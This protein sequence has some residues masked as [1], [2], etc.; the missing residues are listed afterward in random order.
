[1]SN[2]PLSDGGF[3]VYGV[4]IKRLR[5][6]EVEVKAVLKSYS[7]DYF[8]AAL[9][10]ELTG[11]FPN[12]FVTKLPMI[13]SKM[14]SRLFYLSEFE[15]ECNNYPEFKEISKQDVLECLFAAGYIGQHRPRTNRDFT[16]FSYRNHNESFVAEH[17]C[18]LHRGLLKALSL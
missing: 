18:I 5:L 2:P 12:D 14:G 10:D 15:D 6:N 16:V 9:K 4:V 11:F 7:S 3:S 13:L 8:L 1:M 17:E